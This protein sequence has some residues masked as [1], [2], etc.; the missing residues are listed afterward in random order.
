MNRDCTLKRFCC[1]GNC[2][3]GRACPAD[4]PT[5]GDVI[6]AVAVLALPFLLLFIF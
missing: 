5:A 4:S 3:Q 1:N 2:R 6:G